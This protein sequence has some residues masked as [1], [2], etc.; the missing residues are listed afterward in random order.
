[1]DT[2]KDAI[3]AVD[4]A[5]PDATQGLPEDVF[6]MVSRLTPLVNVDLVIRNER[7]DTLLT[8][9]EDQYY[10]PSWHIPG[11]II[12]FR[13]TWDD[14]IQ[15]AARNELRTSVR[16]DPEPLMVRQM[17]APPPRANRAHFISL[18]FACTLEGELDPAMAYDGNGTPRHGQWAWHGFPPPDLIK[19]HIPFRSFIGRGEGIG[20]GEAPESPP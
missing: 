9:R 3:A 14:R 2:L 20:R 5:V 12:R 4:E 13:E 6:Y 19:V 8:W 17:F 18:L 15:A 11:S 16:F 1:M 7:G 10:G